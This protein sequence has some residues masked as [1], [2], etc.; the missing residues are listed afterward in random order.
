MSKPLQTPACS[1]QELRKTSYLTR[2]IRFKKQPTSAIIFAFEDSVYAY[3]NHC[4]HMHRPLNCEQDAIF[5]ESG[6]YLR[7]SMH[8][9]IFDPK[10]GA[11]QSPLCFGQRLQSLCLEEIDGTLYFAGKHLT[12]ID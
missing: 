10:T 11:C 12:L 5:D 6:L 3:I 9:F 8:G 2:K 4:V 1:H 7:C